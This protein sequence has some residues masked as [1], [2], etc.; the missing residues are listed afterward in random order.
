MNKTGSI[1]AKTVGGIIIAGSVIGFAM[2]VA[3]SAMADNE[4]KKCEIE[5]DKHYAVVMSQEGYLQQVNLDRAKYLE[6]Y[7]K[8]MI[9]LDDFNDRVNHTASQEYVDDYMLK[10]NMMKEYSAIKKLKEELTLK[11]LQ[12]DEEAVL[13]GVALIGGTLG[14]ALCIGF[15]VASDEEREASKLGNR[16]Q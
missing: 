4:A 3:N 6:M 15:G 14:G 16:V 7:E 8:R 13:G 5:I 9:D 10:N 11:D 1:I 12:S 2:G